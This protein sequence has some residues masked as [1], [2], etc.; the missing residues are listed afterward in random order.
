[1]LLLLEGLYLFLEVTVPGIV[2]RLPFGI[3]GKLEFM[4]HP[5]WH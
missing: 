2:K 4:A 1:M 5:H 3:G